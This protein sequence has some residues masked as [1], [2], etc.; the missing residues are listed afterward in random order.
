MHICKHKYPK[1][2]TFVCAEL[3]YCDLCREGKCD[4]R[5]FG[6][7][8]RSQIRPIP[9]GESIP[10]Q[11]KTGKFPFKE[12]QNKIESLDKNLKGDVLSKAPCA[13]SN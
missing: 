4:H 9:Y 1:A 2:H 7:T 11:I 8:A 10:F 13:V 12:M 3:I 5:W 6:F